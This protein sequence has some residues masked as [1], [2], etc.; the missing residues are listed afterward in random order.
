MTASLFDWLNWFCWG[1]FGLVWILGAF[2]N[3]YQAPQ[4]AKKRFRYDWLILAGLAWYLDSRYAPHYLHLFRF[5]LPW[6]LPWLAWLGTILLLVSTVF[7]LWSRW[8][9][10]KMWATNAQVKA[11]HRLV[12][13]GPYRITR[14]PIYTGILGM[15]LGSAFSLGEAF[16]V[17]FVLVLIFF[18]NRMRLEE[19]LMVETFGDEYLA[20]RK[21]VPKLIPGLKPR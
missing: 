19:K 21:R 13:G 2:Y 10:G 6:H 3:S 9:L 4:V 5:S 18:F 12:T 8:T 16:A 17:I 14:H 11:E 20:Y 15:I 1:L 7:T